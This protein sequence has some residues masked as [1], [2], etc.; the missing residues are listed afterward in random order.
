MK[1]FK[2]FHKAASAER[3]KI[4]FEYFFPE[5]FKFLGQE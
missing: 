2:F 1:L 5:K 3:Y 4:D